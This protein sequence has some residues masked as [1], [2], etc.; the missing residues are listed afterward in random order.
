MVISNIIKMLSRT[1]AISF[2]KMV[3]EWNGMGDSIF[4][5]KSCTR[6]YTVEDV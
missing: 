4:M 5:E 1:T 3:I 2:M 6:Q